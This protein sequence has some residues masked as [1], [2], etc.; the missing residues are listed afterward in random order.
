MFAYGMD[1]GNVEPLCMNLNT[2]FEL[3]LIGRNQAGRTAF[4]N[5]LLDHLKPMVS[6]GQAEVRILDHYDRPLAQHNGQD[7]VAQ[8]SLDYTKD[9]PGFMLHALAVSRERQT[10]VKAEGSSAIADAPLMVYILNA[11]DAITAI[12]G[13]RE[14]KDAFADMAMNGRRTKILFIFGEIENRAISYSASDILK[15]IKESKQALVF[16]NLG[17]VKCFDVPASVVRANTIRLGPEDAYLFEEDVM[18]RVHLVQGT[19]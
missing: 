3:S 5:A 16:E 6:A 8:Y 13:N 2:Q 7:Y 18:R 9:G 15:H 4:I 12:A 1:Y 11:K 10:L 14:A 17:V 19:V